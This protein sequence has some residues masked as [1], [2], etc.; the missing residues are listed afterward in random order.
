MD[1]RQLL[2]GWPSWPLR[3]GAGRALAKDP[4]FIG[5]MHSHL[6]F[7]GG[8]IAAPKPLASEMA[9]GRRHARR[10][11]AG[12]RSAV[13]AADGAGASSRRACRS[14]ARRGQWFE[15]DLARIKQ[16]IA[17]QN[18]KIV[19]TPG[20]R[21]PRAQGRAARRARGRGRDLRRGR[22]RAAARPPTIWACGTYSSCTTSRTRS[23]TS[24][25]SSPQHNGLTDVRQEGRGGVQPARHPGRSR[26]LHGRGGDAGA[27]ASPRR[28]WCGRTAR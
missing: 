4:I 25:P 8:A 18:L 20:R 12:R 11:V 7:F 26:P 23:A 1:R 19:L 28:R 2:S 24:R 10:L 15:D 14:R 6:F 22:S 5:D 21:R 3:R 16:H 13:A 17:E 27:G 9:A